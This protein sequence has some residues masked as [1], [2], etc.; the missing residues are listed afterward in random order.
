MIQMAIVIVLVSALTSFFITWWA[1][2]SVRAASGLSTS[3][4]QPWSQGILFFVCLIFFMMASG[5]GYFLLGEPKFV[6]A[7]IPDAKKSDA[8][9]ELDNLLLILQKKVSQ[10]PDDEAAWAQLGQ[11]FFI[12]GMPQKAEDA[13][14][15]APNYIQTSPKLLLSY[16]SASFF[17]AG[18]LLSEH[19]EELVDKVLKDN[20]SNPLALWLKGQAEKQRGNIEKARTLFE[21]ALQEDIPQPL[22]VMIQKSLLALTG[23][24]SL[25]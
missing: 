3:P 21:R 4:V 5:V 24:Q 23:S 8:V 6:E 10:N 22:S 14:S 20:G 2:C 12:L 9:S 16:A 11:L 17:N 1:K 13:F 25:Q 19:S 15:E 7:P 18:G